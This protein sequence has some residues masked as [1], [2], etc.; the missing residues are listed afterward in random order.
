M[1]IS[2]E[3]LIDRMKTAQNEI[4][5]WRKDDTELGIRYR[6]YYEGKLSELKNLSRKIEEENEKNKIE[7]VRCKDC[8]FRGNYFL[9]P[10]KNISLYLSDDQVQY[11]DYTTDNSF[12]DVGRRKDK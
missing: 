9:C 8:K 2:K 4:D 1:S 3:Y 11:V 7:V 6:A 12:C 5:Y 10:M